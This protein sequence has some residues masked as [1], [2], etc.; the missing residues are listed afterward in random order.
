MESRK[1]RPIALPHALRGADYGEWVGAQLAQLGEA[2]IHLVEEAIDVWGQ[3]DFFADDRWHEAERN[4]K[5]MQDTCSAKIESIE[6]KLALLNTEQDRSNNGDTGAMQSQLAETQRQ[7]AATKADLQHEQQM[8]MKSLDEKEM[9][10]LKADQM[11]QAEK[12][13]AEE[14]AKQLE[15]AKRANPEANPSSAS[16]SAAELQAV[17]DKLHRTEGELKHAQDRLH[18]MEGELKQAKQSAAERKDF[19]DKLHKMEGELK[20]A[21]QSEEHARKEVEQLRAEVTGAREGKDEISGRMKELESVN[22]QLRDQVRP[23]PAPR[24]SPSQPEPCRAAPRRVRLPRRARMRRAAR[25]A[26]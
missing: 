8:Y 4:V 13:R 5:Q 10:L 6:K 25:R 7:L 18:K 2:G 26:A 11:V 1:G 24:A 9:R 22:K 23:C 15:D 16:A 17:E 20:Q 3:M 14:L 12:R 21:K 19:Q